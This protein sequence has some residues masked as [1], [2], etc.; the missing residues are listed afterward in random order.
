MIQW[1]CSYD[2]MIPVSHSQPGAEYREGFGSSVCEC[3]CVR[4]VSFS[5]LSVKA[6]FVPPLGVLLLF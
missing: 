3:V 2:N 5:V 4:T 6:A 1:M